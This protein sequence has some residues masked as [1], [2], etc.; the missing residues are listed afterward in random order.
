MF[1]GQ[2]IPWGRCAEDLYQREPVARAALDRCDKV[3]RGEFGVS[4]LEVMF[5]RNGLETVKHGP[6]WELPGLYALQCALTAQWA[7][8]GIRPSAI[9]AGCFGW[10]AAAQ[11]AGM[12]SL[13]DGLR[14]AETLG[15]IRKEKPEQGTASTLKD[16]EDT[17]DMLNLGMPSI[18]L[19]DCSSGLLKESIGIA[20]VAQ[21]LQPDRGAFD[22]IGCAKSLAELAVN[23]VV[24][25]GVDSSA[26]E[27]VGS[28]WPDTSEAPLVTT[29]LTSTADGSETRDSDVGFLRAVASLYEAGVNMSFEGLFVG[30]ARR[31]IS[32]PTY[33]FQRRRHW[34]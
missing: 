31:R 21:W 32:V 2:E 12:F 11:A 16:L 9:V 33:P 10:L 28:N 4:L 29:T 13:E 18:P 27:M 19:I 17:M 23:A 5:G 15:R 8:L 14:F 1:T 3:V 7:S 34:F 20:D 24:E 6:E 25:V 30:E 22:Y 26:R